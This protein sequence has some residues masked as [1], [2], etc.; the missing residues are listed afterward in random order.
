LKVPKPPHVVANMDPLKRKL[1]Y[2]NKAEIKQSQES[3]GDICDPH[4]I[5]FKVEES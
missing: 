1:S 2:F 5:S 4:K 3:Q